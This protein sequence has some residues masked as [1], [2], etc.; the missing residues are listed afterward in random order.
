[1]ATTTLRSTNGMTWEE[2]SSDVQANFVVLGIDKQIFDGCYSSI[3]W[4]KLD[5]MAL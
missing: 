5:R 2:L 1:M 4:G 3:F